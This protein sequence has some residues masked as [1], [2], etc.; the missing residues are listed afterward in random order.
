MNDDERVFWFSYI[1]NTLGLQ[2]PAIQQRRFEVVLLEC[3]NQLQLDSEQLLVRLQN[4]P[5]VWAKLIDQLAITETQF[6]RHLPSYD[7]VKGFLESCPESVRMW[8]AGCSSGEEVWSLAMLAT[9]LEKDFQIIAT[10]LSGAA[11]SKAQQAVYTE[12]KIQYLTR[13]RQERFLEASSERAECYRVNESL[14]KTVSFF[15]HNLTDEQGLPL[16]QI[17]LIFCQNVLIY[18]RGFMQRDILNRLFETLRPGG[19]LV[20]GPSEA[21]SWKH[22]LAERVKHAGALAYIKKAKTVKDVA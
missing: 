4:D 6:F 1:E 11:L 22:P 15:Q 18:F 12:R 13:Q 2:L 3:M 5:A 8:S 14:K 10:D 16:R 9:E 17:D 20:L 19:V 7:L 21:A